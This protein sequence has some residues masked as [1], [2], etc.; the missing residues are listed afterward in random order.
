MFQS[1]LVRWTVT[2]LG[3]DGAL[4]CILEFEV[5]RFCGLSVS[6]LPSNRLFML[7]CI[8]GCLLNRQVDF[9]FEVYRIVSTIQRY[10]CRQA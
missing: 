4:F 7:I 8:M 2:S 5:I 6:Q 3:R 10:L 1:G 9:V